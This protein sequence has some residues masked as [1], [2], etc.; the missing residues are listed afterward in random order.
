MTRTNAA[1]SGVTLVIGLVALA[2]AL[3]RAQAGAPAKSAAGARQGG[4]PDQG[5]RGGGRDDNPTAA[6]FTAQCSGCHGT[7]LAG[8]RA[9]SL[10]DERWLASTTDE[11]IANAIRYGV[12]N[13]TMAPFKSLSDEQIWHLTQYMRTQSGV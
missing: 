2:I 8:G 6:L 12:A 10:F 1:V 5:G 11:R 3:P 13:T 4:A 9:P 7:D